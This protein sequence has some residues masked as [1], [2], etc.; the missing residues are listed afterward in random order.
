MKTTKQI[1]LG[2]AYIG[3]SYLFATLVSNE[4]PTNFI[5]G[6]KAIMSLVTSII[7]AYVGTHK[8]A[9]ELI[10]LIYNNK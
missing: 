8:I 6:W 4:D 10:G 7:F 5:Q 3:I 9:V 1:L 2:I